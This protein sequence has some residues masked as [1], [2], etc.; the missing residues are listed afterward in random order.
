MT[1]VRGVGECGDGVCATGRTA[2]DGQLAAGARDHSGQ[3]PQVKK[4]NLRDADLRGADMSTAKGLT[5]K[6][7]SVAR[8]DGLT[9]LPPGVARPAPTR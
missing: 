9:R 4:A 3:Q 5:S 1:V 2:G 6:Q 7:L 8:V